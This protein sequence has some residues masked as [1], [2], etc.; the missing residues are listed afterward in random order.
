M[1]SFLGITFCFVLIPTMGF[2]TGCA[3]GARTDAMV[4]SA[5]VAPI[6]A[7][8]PAALRSNIA[9]AD[10]TGGS[11]T[12]P[13]WVSKVGGVEFERALEGSL[14]GVGMLQPNRQ[15]GSYRLFADLQRVDQ[16][17]VGVSLTVTSTVQYT[18]VERASGKTVFDETISAPYTAKFSDAVFGF[19]RLK[20]ANEGS[21]RANIERLIQRLSSLALTD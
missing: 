4:V 9:I 14:Q 8:A 3:S 12:N 6:A 11:S 18:L 15:S 16:P 5:S 10:V 2:L 1:R 13:L 20:L 19:E 7:S 21:I 17:M